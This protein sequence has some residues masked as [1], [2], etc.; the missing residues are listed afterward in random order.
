MR[1]LLTRPL[2]Q[3]QSLKAKLEAAGHEV[4]CLPL[5]EIL[6][7]SDG[8]AALKKAL[9]EISKYQWLVFT[10]G[11]AVEAVAQY[12]KKLPA[13]LK[14]LAI[15]SA[16]S[17]AIGD[18]GWKVEGLLGS[19]NLSKLKGQKVLYP[20]SSIGLEKWVTK[21]QNA[22][23]AV[24][25]VEAYQTHPSKVSASKLHSIIKKGVDGIL[26][27]SPSAVHHFNSIISDSKVASALL[28]IPFGPT[29]A[30]ALEEHGLKPTFMF[31]ELF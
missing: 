5:I 12:L 13:Q 31:Q 3:S 1:L 26:F 6:P 10:S 28:F 27:F 21:L 18:L 30:K 4:E 23:A 29:T 11:N 20:R 9:S 7:P 19:F 25:V 24:N 22:G 2:E 14:I 8:G 16:T 17:Q 15:G